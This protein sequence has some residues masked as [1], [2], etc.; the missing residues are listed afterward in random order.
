MRV[1][2][3]RAFHTHG[4]GIIDNKKAA[5]AAHGNGFCRME[6]QKRVAA[7]NDV[8]GMGRCALTVALPIISAAG[9]ETCVLPT[10]V[11]STHTGGFVDYTF[12]DL[13]EDI[14]PFARHWQS[15]HAHFDAV[16]TGY[17]G[18]FE[19]QNMVG[20]VID[21]FHAPDTLVIVDPIMADN[22]LLYPN[23]SLEFARGMARLCQKADVIVPNIT[24][25]VFMLG[26]T[27]HEGP[28]TRAYIEGL[29]HRLSD[30]G[31]KQVVL[32][33]VYFDD[34]QLGAATLDRA[35]GRIGYALTEKIPGLYAGTGD[36]FA[37]A[38]TAGLVKGFALD[39]AAQIAADFTV[40]SIKRTYAAQADLRYG[41]NFEQ[42]LPGFMR[43]LGVLDEP[44]R[45]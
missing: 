34:Q 42:S 5:P 21:M 30:T 19:Q 1:A 45:G 4:R 35:T 16:Y 43:A 26:E 6:K 13:T 40:E 14:L 2:D 11:L 44:D 37:S 8:S 15:E 20:E 28:Y 10:A 29:L 27:Y 39:R 41:V 33:G 36:V 23:F 12:R 3:G 18:S 32:T 24:E 9:I 17:L 31:A 7:I 38:L 22:G 25:A